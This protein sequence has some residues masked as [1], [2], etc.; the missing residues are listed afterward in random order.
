MGCSEDAIKSAVDTLEKNRPARELL[1]PLFKAGWD[2]FPDTG[3]SVDIQKKPFVGVLAHVSDG[4]FLVKTMPGT[5]GASWIPL[6]RFLL[7]RKP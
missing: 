4:K 3:A 2:E 7:T 5:Q 1:E 6:T